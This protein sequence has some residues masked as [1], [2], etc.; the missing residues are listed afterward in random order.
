MLSS[1][2]ISAIGRAVNTSSHEERTAPKPVDFIRAKVAED[3][4]T[5]KYGGRVA[6]RF[7]PEPNGFLHIGHAKAI[8][9][10]FGIALEKEGGTCNLRFDDTNPITEEEK[11]TQAI[12]RDIHWLGFDWEDRLYYASDYFDK[13]YAYAVKLVEEG[14]AYVDSLNEEQIRAYRGTVTEPGRESPYRNRSTGANLDLLARMKDGEFEDGAH[15]LRAKID[16]ASPN[17]LMRDP[18]LYRIRHAHHYRTGDDWCIYPMYDFAHCLEDAI[19]GITHSLCSLEFKDNRELYDWVLREVEIPNPPEQTEFARLDLDYTVLSKRKLIRLVEEGRVGGW[20]D[21]RMPTLAGLRRRGVTPASIRTFCDMIGVARVDSRVDIG[22]LE[23]CIR[24]DL[25][26][27]VPR[28]LCVLRPLRIVITNYP[29]GEVEWLDA[30]YYPHDV[31]KEGSRKL[32]FSRV[33][34]VERNDFEEHP[35]PKFFR[36]APGREVRL[37]YGYFIRCDEVVKDPVSGEVTELLCSYDPETKG[38]AA[39]D[40]RKVKGTI[41]WVSAEHSMPVEIRLYDR[42][43]SVPNPDDP[44]HGDD[45]TATLNP[46]S[47]LTLSDSRIEPS[48]ADDPPGTKYQFE[49]QGYFC[50]DVVDSSSDHLVF[51]RTVSLRDT[52]AK[53]SVAAVESHSTARTAKGEAEDGEHAPGAPA[54]K[55][56]RARVGTPEYDDRVARYSGLGLGTAEA[57]VLADHRGLAEFFEET[58]TEYDNPKAVA[59]WVINDVMRVIKGTDLGELSFDAKQLGSLVR[60]V[61]DGVVSRT[62]AKDVFTDMVREGG[63]PEAIIRARGLEQV[64]DSNELQSLVEK[65]VADHSVEVKRYREGKKALLGFFVGQVMR[66]SGGKAS[67]TLVRQLVEKQLG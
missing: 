62:I 31:P 43:F 4:R 36:L 25:N 64:S 27:E 19:E 12:Q 22:K 59:G 24:D 63:D 48:V 21:P 47:L 38:G 61:D 34:Y 41:H 5:N 45:F 44:R 6:T 58:L 33:I 7:P 53:I 13:F 65:V 17:M 29:E 30:P 9:L 3:L 32:P 51:N 57:K 1:I 20:D 60:L 52:W 37:R 67:P 66:E 49:R 14:K 11:Y 50:S 15:V 18:L 2:L 28:V 35:Q 56:K 16:M 54:E 42:L 55:L 39:P 26:R 46:Q 40:G 10:N 23:F 8:C